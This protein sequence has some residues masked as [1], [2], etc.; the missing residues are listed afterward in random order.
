M[1]NTHPSPESTHPVRIARRAISGVFLL[2]KPLGLSSN[3]ALQRV[4]YL[5]Q[6]LKAGHTG[7]L[8]PLATGLLP[9]CLGQT[10]RFSGVVLEAPKTY[11]ACIRLGYTSSTGDGEG[12]I[13]SGQVYRGDQSTLQQVLQGFVGQQ[14]QAPPMHSALKHQGKPLYVYARAGVNIERPM[15]SIHIHALRQLSWQGDELNI[16]VQVSKGTYIR[17]LAQDIGTALGCGAYLSGLRRSP[18]GPEHVA[19]ALRLEQLEQLTLAQREACLLATDTLLQE[20]PALQLPAQLARLLRHGQNL[21]IPWQAL[22]G[23]RAPGEETLVWAAVP[24]PQTLRLYD[25]DQQFLGLGEWN[26]GLLRPARLMAE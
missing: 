16:S 4:R 2:D 23:M 5:F 18:S 11:E 24:T 15:R 12:V 26:A 8:D 3:S 13:E 17:V 7:T 20:F 14:Q 22:D 19:Q 10:T 21:S 9:I 6:A 25:P 1:P